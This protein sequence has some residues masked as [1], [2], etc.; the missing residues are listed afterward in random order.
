MRKIILWLIKK[1]LSGYHLRKNPVQNKKMKG[2]ND[3]Q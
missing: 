1:F 3:G 2:E